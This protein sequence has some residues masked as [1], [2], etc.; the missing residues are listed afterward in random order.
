M[1]TP[2]TRLAPVGHRLPAFAG[3][4]IAWAFVPTVQTILRPQIRLPARVTLQPARCIFV[5]P[6][7]HPIIA[8]VDPRLT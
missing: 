6:F 4:M 2:R 7:G 5:L 3:V 8:I 1:L